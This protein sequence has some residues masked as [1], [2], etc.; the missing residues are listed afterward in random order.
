MSRL[1]DENLL[2]KSLR[3]AEMRPNSATLRCERTSTCSSWDFGGFHGA[4][5]TLASTNL[6]IVQWITELRCS[7]IYQKSPGDWRLSTLLLFLF[8]IVWNQSQAR[9][10]HPRFSCL[11]WFS[12]TV[13]VEQ[14]TWN[15]RNFQQVGL[16]VFRISFQSHCLYSTDLCSEWIDGWERRK[17]MPR[18]STKHLEKSLEWLVFGSALAELNGLRFWGQKNLNKIPA[19]PD[20]TQLKRKRNTERGDCL[21]EVLNHSPVT[22]GKTSKSMRSFRVRNLPWLARK[23]FIFVREPL[24]LGGSSWFRCLKSQKR[25]CWVCSQGIKANM[26]LDSQLP[27]FKG[28]ARLWSYSL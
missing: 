26:I 17:R 1:Q 22:N 3:N 8:R 20:G 15:F 14:G 23:H 13:N 25:T 10:Q 27:P 5:T 21:D 11:H 24:W 16:R 7:P 4:A 12:R 28:L 18:T 6:Q 19:P 9:A 2:E